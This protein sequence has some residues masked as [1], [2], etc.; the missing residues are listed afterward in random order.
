MKS[1]IFPLT[2]NWR[3]TLGTGEHYAVGD[4]KRRGDTLLFKLLSRVN[5]WGMT[6]CKQQG[7]GARADAITEK[8][9][10]FEPEFQGSSSAA[11]Y[12][13]VAR[14]DERRRAMGDCCQ[15]QSR[16]RAIALTGKDWL[17]VIGYQGSDTKFRLSYTGLGDHIGAIFPLLMGD[18][19]QG[20][21]I[22]YFS[23]CT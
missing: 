2:E 6:A 3:G 4:S 15:L 23:V 17:S 9:S 13:H 19:K 1:P 18:P 5:S 22:C 8:G 10:M 16:L 14:V 20:L 21:M 12:C 7:T 11:S